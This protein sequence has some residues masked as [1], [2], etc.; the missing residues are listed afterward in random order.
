MRYLMKIFLL[1]MAL[2]FVG[3]GIPFYFDSIDLDREPA[4][5]DETVPVYDLNFDLSSHDRYIHELTLSMPVT[6]QQLEELEQKESLLQLSLILN[7]TPMMDLTDLSTEWLAEPDSSDPEQ[8]HYTTTVVVN[9]RELD[10]PDGIYQ[11]SIIPDHD[12]S[13]R[14]SFDNDEKRIPLAMHSIQFYQRALH[15]VVGSGTALRLF[16]PD[17]SSHYLIPVTRFLDTVQSPMVREVIRQL[18]A[19]PASDFDLF[20]RSP[21]PPVP[22]VWLSGGTAELYLSSNLGFYNE[23]SNV[24]RMAA[25]S[26]VESLGSLPDVQRVQF[27]FDQQV[28]SEGF[29]GVP[30]DSPMEPVTGPLYYSGYVSPE[31]RLFLYP[32]PMENDL[33]SVSNIFQAMTLE[34]QPEWYGFQMQP[35]I[36]AGIELLDYSLMDDVL[37]V[38]INRRFE[39]LYE[40]HPH[41][42]IFM[43]DSLVL[44][45]TSLDSVNSVLLQVE[46]NA[47][48]WEVPFTFDQP[49]FPPAYPNP[50]TV[51]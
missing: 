44:S 16:F 46:G 35:A 49:L 38:N 6:S 39:D 8:I 12:A 19:G 41:L 32:L 4:P 42:A 13:I 15:D 11:V 51:Q 14:F 36:P 3:S 28:I 25:F 31:G 18:E 50:E 22:R 37:Y 2:V 9:Q 43:V 23:Y 30:T 33:A 26:L 21:I 20:N 24:S 5:V 17:E 45:L 47:P 27:Y 1:L 10:L 29:R 48:S 7:D 40:N 34:H